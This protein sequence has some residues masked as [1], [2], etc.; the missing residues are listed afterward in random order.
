MIFL[1]ILIYESRV[2][3]Q[4][5]TLLNN[6]RVFEVIMAQ[7]NRKHKA[8]RSK[9]IRSII[10][11]KS[12]LTTYRN[13]CDKTWILISRKRKVSWA[14]IYSHNI[15]VLLSHSKTAPKS[16]FSMASAIF[17]K[18][19]KKGFTRNTHRALILNGRSERI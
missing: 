13:Q 6:L 3:V 5:K 15:T 10:Q 11:I 14:Q 7:K 2:C 1:E 12:I 18:K 9:K 16:S 19:E 17:L 8:T 4:Y